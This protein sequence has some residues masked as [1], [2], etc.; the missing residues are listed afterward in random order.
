MSI[1]IVPK[2]LSLLPKH[3]I[4]ANPQAIHIIWSCCRL[5]RTVVVV[6]HR[7]MCGWPITMGFAESRGRVIQWDRGLAHIAGA[8]PTAGGHWKVSWKTKC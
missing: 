2:T 8:Q 4:V 3:P 5:V 1:V 6:V 7:E